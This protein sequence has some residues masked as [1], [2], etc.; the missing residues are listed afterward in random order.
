MDVP[1][2]VSRWS[3]RTR[4]AALAALGAAV[5]LP[6]V[7]AT[8]HAGLVGA[9]DDALSAEL[10]IRATDVA[11]LVGD[12]GAPTLP[13]AAQ[14]LLTQVVD[15]EGVVLAP[16]GADPLLDPEVVAEAQRGEV[17]VSGR[18]PVVGEARILAIPVPGRDRVVVVATSSGPVD[19]ARGRLLVVLGVGGPVAVG[20]VGGLGWF[21]TGVALDPVARMARRAETISLAEPHERLPPPPGRDELA[22]LGRTLNGMLAR[23]EATLARE[24]AFVDDASHELRTPIAVLRGELELALLEVRAGA[25]PERFASSLASALDEVDR[26]ARVAEHLLVLARVDAQPVAVAPVSL[27][28]VTA[29]VVDRLGGGDREV[30]VSGTEVH[31]EVDGDLLHQVVVNILSN[32]QRHATRRVRVEVSRDGGQGILRVAD[33]GPGFPDGAER[34]LERFARGDGVRSRDG[35]GAGLGL[36]IVAAVVGGAGG[37]VRLGRSELLGGAVVEVRVPVATTESGPPN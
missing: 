5:V 8:L 17:V 7:A 23:I 3:L 1:R 35:G 12:P 16:I 10:R 22:D 30:A 15:G 14:G 26:L 27:L 31:V 29:Q 20:V 21:L 25:D 37:T 19:R 33:D 13:D 28:E 6:V 11:A 4:V 9:L 32:A 18:I 34:L 24:R 36:A 2:W